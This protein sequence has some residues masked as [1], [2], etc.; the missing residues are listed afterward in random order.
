MFKCGDYVLV[1]GTKRGFIEQI[2]EKP[3]IIFCVFYVIDNVRDKQVTPDQCTLTSL[4]DGTS[5]RSGFLRGY[6]SPPLP[7]TTSINQD[8]TITSKHC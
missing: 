5:M 2:N 8:K 4:H 6:H 3:N 1:D 7:S